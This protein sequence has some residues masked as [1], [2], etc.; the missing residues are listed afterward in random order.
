MSSKW[1]AARPPEDSNDMLANRLLVSIEADWEKIAGDVS[2]QLRKDQAAG[3]YRN[4][5]KR[6]I[7]D[8][9]HEL[10]KNLGYWLDSE[11]DEA[12]KSRYEELGRKRFREGVALDEVQYKILLIKRKIR[13]HAMDL[14]LDATSLQL[15]Q[16]LELLRK[17]AHC[18]DLIVCAVARG[19]I[20]AMRREAILSALEE[21]P[22]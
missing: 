21:T 2:R 5:P 18:F 7:K 4:L 9:A 15:H 8:R 14:N 6:E 12:L 16:E 10:V 19:Y 11:N 3:F 20:D 13:S 22:A 17:M 1:V